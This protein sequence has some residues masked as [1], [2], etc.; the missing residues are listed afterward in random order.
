M[1]DE[2]REYDEGRPVRPPNNFR[3][4]YLEIGDR[5]APRGTRITARLVFGLL[6]FTL[7]ALWT[8]DNLGVIDSGPIMAWWPALLI[9]LGLGKVTGVIPG[10]R[11]IVM[12]AVF[13]I[14]GFLLLANSL[15]LF[16]FHFWQLWPL[17]LIVAGTSLVVRSMRGPAAADGA[18]RSA[19][20]HTF[21]LM[22]GIH[23][24]FDTQDFRGGDASALMGGVEIDLRSARAAQPQVVIDVFAWWGGID[25]FVPRDWRVVN[26]VVPIMGGVDDQTRPA[27]GEVRT[28]LLLRG[29]AIMGGIEIKN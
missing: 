22:A 1:S 23:Q 20:V 9:L 4:V 5:N 17:L 19:E 14:V 6:I 10:R 21:A 2:R 12:G 16:S 24:K 8:L 25:V 28:T 18:D 11:Q 26:E 29:A 15:G 3:G 27:E 7:G 13:A